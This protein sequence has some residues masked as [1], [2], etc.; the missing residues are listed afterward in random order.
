MLSTPAASVTAVA[1]ACGFFSLGHFSRA[2]RD[3]FGELPSE[4]IRRSA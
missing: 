4:T 2:Y 1:F 3:A